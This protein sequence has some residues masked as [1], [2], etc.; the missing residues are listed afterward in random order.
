MTRAGNGRLNGGCSAGRTSQAVTLQ[1]DWIIT[2]SG[3]VI[4]NGRVVIRDGRIAAVGPAK[5]V[6]TVGKLVR[7]EESA[8]LPGLINAHCH[9]ELSAY[10]GAIGTGD[11][12]QWLSRL[13]E[14]RRQRQSQQTEPPAA[15]VAI[16]SMLRAGTTCVGDI[17]RAPW[18][19]DILAASG[20]RKV[21]FVELISHARTAP[22]DPAGLAEALQSLRQTDLLQAGISP[23]SPYTVHAEHV[24]ACIEL[25]RRNRLPLAMHFA[26]T[27]EEAEWLRSG[28]GRTAQWQAQLLPNPPDPPR[29]PPCRWLLELGLFR[30][31]TVALVHANYADDWLLLCRMPPSRRP[32][33]VYC[34]RTH[35]FFGHGEH[36]FGQMLRMGLPVALGTDS[37]ASHPDDEPEPLSVLEEARWL[38]AAHPDLPASI[39]L[40]ML[41]V[42]AARALGLQD[43]IGQIRAGFEADLVA[44]RCT[45]RTNEPLEEILHSSVRPHLV[46]VRGTRLV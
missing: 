25:A 30:C 19:P 17:V 44:F 32:V 41:T 45:S 29:C 10:H 28:Q 12:W 26:E 21:C 16:D 5:E 31:P 39:I 40:Q 27:A 3:P 24:K 43:R 9:I 1:A 23:H 38:A 7:L 35:R 34:P 4:R 20:I 33:I 6:P 36:P 15:Q 42:N 18:M 22:R 2:A 11:F 14:L 8:L 46:M 13:I 37:A